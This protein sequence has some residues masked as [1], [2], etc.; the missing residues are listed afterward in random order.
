MAGVLTVL[1]SSPPRFEIQDESLVFSKRQ[2]C[3]DDD[4]ALWLSYSWAATAA[5]AACVRRDRCVR[6][7]IL[8][9]AL[10]IAGYGSLWKG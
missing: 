6:L 7:H 10:R 2:G 8:F 5:S 1:F 4:L 3:L 9:S